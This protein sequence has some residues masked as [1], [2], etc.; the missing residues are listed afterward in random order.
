MGWLRGG[1][2]W[3]FSGVSDVSC[4]FVRMPSCLSKIYPE[5]HS[6][7]NTASLL[8][9]LGSTP[10]PC[11]PSYQVFF[12]W[13][14]PCVP[15]CERKLLFLLTTDPANLWF[16]VVVC[17]S[18][19]CLISQGGH[20]TLSH[21]ALSWEVSANQDAAGI[22]WESET[23]TNWVNWKPITLE[24]RRK[25]WGREEGCELTGYICGAPGGPWDCYLTSGQKRA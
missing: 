11:L 21:P 10:P 6:T 3:W 4:F 13:G 25:W 16:A 17:W 20:P 14:Q 12:S 24:R 2:G 1:G 5:S 15:T 19:R 23:E 9:A 8:S 18:P 7:Y 22:A